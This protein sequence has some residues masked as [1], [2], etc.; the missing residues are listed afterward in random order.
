MKVLVTGASGLLGSH[1]A[2]A[3]IAEGHDVVA[4][5]RHR[6]LAQSDS[7][8]LHRERAD[9]ANGDEVARLLDRWKPDGV[10]HVAARIPVDASEHD[11]FTFFDDNVRATLNLLHAAT[12]IGVKRFIL[13]STLSVYG[14]PQYL[15]VDESH[16]LEPET[17]Y[18]LSKLEG[19]GYGRLYS[20]RSAMRVTVL[21]YS[22]I[23]GKG[24]Q[25]GAIPAFIGRCAANEPLILHADGRQSS[26]FVWVED[27]ARANLLALE[28]DHLPRF[29]VFNIGSGIEITIAELANR[30]RELCG[31]SSELRPTGQS[32]GRDFRFVFDI[33]K[34]RK[35]LGYLPTAQ[36][37]ALAR[38]LA[39]WVD[40][41]WFGSGSR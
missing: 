1:L 13:S 9:L 6:E 34:A 32:C 22:G 20:A 24:Q 33:E 3:A 30:I 23:Y 11:P 28:A 8:R 17:A 4:Q 38:C 39:Q 25:R 2:A 40:G 12:R 10:F 18:G 21:R 16:P 29:A 41:E 27:A 36:D 19:E 7:P 15:P 31:S 26:D 5:S 35:T 14:T 37:Q